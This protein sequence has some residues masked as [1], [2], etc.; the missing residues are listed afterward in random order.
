MNRTPSEMWEYEVRVTTFVSNG[1]RFSFGSPTSLILLSSSFQGIY[2]RASVP[3]SSVIW[4]TRRCGILNLP[5]LM[6]INR[7]AHTWSKKAFPVNWLGS[8]LGSEGPNCVGPRIYRR[9]YRRLVHCVVINAF[10]VN[11]TNKMNIE[12][13]HVAH[14]NW[15]RH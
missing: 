3:Y 10:D 5:M 13:E 7:V 11:P 8:N 6:T 9:D 4:L 12:T 1:S 2:W 15:Y 14:M